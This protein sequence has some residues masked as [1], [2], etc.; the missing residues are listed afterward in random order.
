MVSDAATPHG[1]ESHLLSAYTTRFT[2][3]NIDLQKYYQTFMGILVFLR[4]FQE[5][6]RARLE[7]E[8]AKQLSLRLIETSVLWMATTN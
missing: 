5:K 2:G 1:A 8:F 7:E 3:A 4:F 6:T